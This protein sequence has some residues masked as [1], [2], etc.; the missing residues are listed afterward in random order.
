MMDEALDRKSVVTSDKVD[1]VCLV[2]GAAY[3]SIDQ[4]ESELCRIKILAGIAPLDTLSP[5][6]YQKLSRSNSIMIN[7]TGDWIDSGLHSLIGSIDKL[8]EMIARV[9]PGSTLFVPGAVTEAMLPNLEAMLQRGSSTLLLRHPDNLKASYEKLC[10]FVD[11]ADIKTLIPF[12]IQLVAINSWA[13]GI[14]QADADEFR[15]RVKSIFDGEITID[16]MDDK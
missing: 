2:A 11:R 15:D 16:I 14:N 10:S 12:K 9:D 7:H 13:P 1:A 5:I 3:G 4:I 8:G 6:D